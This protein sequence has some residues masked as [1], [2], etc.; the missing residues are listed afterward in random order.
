MK[1]FGTS[2]RYIRLTRMSNFYKEVNYARSACNRRRSG[3]AYGCRGRSGKRQQSRFARTKRKSRPQDNDNR[4]GQVQCHKRLRRPQRPYLVCARKRQIS[5]Q[6][7]FALHARGYNELLRVAARPAQDR[8]RQPSV[9]GV[10]Q[11]VRYSRRAVLRGEARGGG[12]CKRQSEGAHNRGRE[13]FAARYFIP[14]SGYIP[15]G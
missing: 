4:K 11:S 9:P 10:G 2:I 7:V 5:L 3:G 8:A 14:A 6:R 1:I 15:T 12:Y 13:R